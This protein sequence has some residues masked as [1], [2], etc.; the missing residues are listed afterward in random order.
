MIMVADGV[1]GWGEV[2][3]DSGIFSRFLCKEI[4]KIYNAKPAQ[5]LKETLVQA[6]QANPHGG[7]TTAVICK[8]DPEG[9]K[10]HTCNLGDSGYLIVR[11]NEKGELEKHFMSKAQTYSFDFPYQ[12]GQNCELPYDAIDNEHEVR[13]NDIVVVGTDGLFDNLF[14]DQIIKS[15]IKPHV[16]D[17]HLARPEDASLC[18]ASLAEAIA[19]SETHVSPYTQDAIDHGEKKEDHLGG[20]PD[21][22]TVIVAQVKLQ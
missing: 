3:V 15:C 13:H 9:K 1:G 11:A 20:K 12:C 22:I 6:V 7:S 8:L 17:G 10:M 5:S 21:D 4:A 19:Y 2:D 16:K 14:P 18:T